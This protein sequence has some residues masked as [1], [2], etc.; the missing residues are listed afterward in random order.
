MTILFYVCLVIGALKVTEIIM[1]LLSCLWRHAIRTRPA[2]VF[3]K[4]GG[5]GAWAIVTG[6]SDGI[7]LSLCH[8]LAA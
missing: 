1:R 5:R 7:G 4:Y 3:A 8:E 2:N 6:G